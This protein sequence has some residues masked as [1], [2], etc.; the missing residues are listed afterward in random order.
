MRVGGLPAICTPGGMPV[1]NTSSPRMSCG[2]APR[3]VI[4]RLIEVVYV[5]LNASDKLSDQMRRLHGLLL[6]GRVENLE[7]LEMEHP[8]TTS[9]PSA[10]LPVAQQSY[11]RAAEPPMQ[12]VAKG[13]R[14]PA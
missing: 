11:L 7:R 6:S 9:T 8:T 1:R 13:G 3:I 12:L 4:S 5:G 14:M 10:S 2:G